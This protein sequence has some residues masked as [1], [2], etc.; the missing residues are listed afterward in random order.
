[1]DTATGAFTTQ[2]LN[3]IIST[4]P[5]SGGSATLL[6]GKAGDRFRTIIFGH[7]NAVGIPAAYMAG[8]AYSVAG[9]P[10]HADED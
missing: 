5:F 1:V 6:L 7:L 8:Y 10:K 4:S 3:T 2:N 9:G